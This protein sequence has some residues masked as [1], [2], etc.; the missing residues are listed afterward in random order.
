M[1]DDLSTV[2]LELAAL[3]EQVRLLA[4][5]VER[6]ARTHVGADFERRER[7]GL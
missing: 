1:A 2:R 4:E 3:R 5:A 7:F 6:H